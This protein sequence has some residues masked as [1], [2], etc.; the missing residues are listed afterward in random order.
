M[1]GPLLPPRFELIGELGTGAMGTVYAARDQ[2]LGRDVAVKVFHHHDRLAIDGLK[3][4]FRVAAGVRHRN[5]IRLGELFDHSAGWCFS[6][7]KIDGK[8]VVPWVARGRPGA[9]E[10]TRAVVAQVAAA[11]A[12][13]H[14]A[15]VIHLDVRPSNVLVEADGRVV[16][17][18]LG[19]A[20]ALS[21]ARP[22][23]LV[24]SVEYL[25]PEQSGADVTT[26]ATDVY[27]LGVLLYELLTGEPPFTGDPMQILAAKAAT[28]PPPPSQRVADVPDDLDRLCATLLAREPARRPTAAAVAAQLGEVN[29][30]AGDAER[31]RPALVGRDR[32]LTEL[33][34]AAAAAPAANRTTVVLL[35]GETGVGKTALLY[36]FA[37]AARAAGHL[38]CMGA[39]SPREHLRWNAWDGL[40]D[41]L[42]Q[43]LVELPLAERGALLPDDAGVLVHLFPAFGRVIAAAPTGSRS[44]GELIRR[45]TAALRELLRRVAATR[46]LVSIV[47]D[48][49]YTTDDSFALLLDVLAA[50]SAPMLMVIGSRRT[51]TVPAR[52]L[53]RAAALQALPIE[54]RVLDVG[55]LD[56]AASLALARRLTSDPARAAAVCAAAAG[57]P[58]FLEQLARAP[59]GLATDVGDLLR[60]RLTALTATERAILRVLTA[61]RGALRLDVIGG[62]VELEHEPLAHQLEALGDAGLV[63][64]SGLT[65]ADHA[66]V[67]H[68]SIGEAVDA[69]AGA[70][71]MAR[72]HAAL[73]VALEGMPYDVDLL[74]EHWVAAGDTGRAVAAVLAAAAAARDALAHGHVATLCDLVTTRTL[75]VT[76]HAAIAGAR[77][78]ALAG[79]GRIE[80]AALAYQDAATAT[81]G[82]AALDLRRTA[83]ELLLR[84]G[85]I[86]DGHAIAH[87]L[88]AQLGMAMDLPPRL[89]IG[90]I[91]LE[92]LRL[93]LRGRRLAAR[94]DERQR[95]AGATCTSLAIG[96]SM[97]DM[98]RA[99][100]F[101]SRAVRLSLDSGDPAAAALALAFDGA[102]VASRGRATAAHCAAIF[103]RADQLATSTTDATL[104]YVAACR[105]G[106]AYA[107]GDFAGAIEHCDRAR[108]IYDRAP[109]VE[110]GRCSAELIA[111]AACYWRGD[112]ATLARH[113]AELANAAE[114]TGDRYAELLAASGFAVLPDALR[115]D[116]AGARARLEQAAAHWP[117]DLAPTAQ[118]RILVG[119][120]VL[121]LYFGHVGAARFRIEAAW[122]E[123]VASKGLVIEHARATMLDLR[124]R[125]AVAGGDLDTAAA[126]ARELQRIAWATGPAHL[127]HAAVAMGRGRRGDAAAALDRAVAAAELHGLAAVAAAARFRRGELTAGSASDLDRRAAQAAAATLGLGDG[128]LP[129]TL[130]AP[131]PT[132]DG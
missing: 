22:A 111:L 12:A 16:L 58:L 29:V 17:L 36:D 102:L 94:R 18:D 46:R 28:D 20:S 86:A 80:A 115:G 60:D 42:S 72:A 35:R 126:A 53:A 41:F 118:F 49:R 30:G 33:L 8:D 85:R 37:A 104:G 131:W 3:Q 74:V 87:S 113:R 109:G 81:T 91:A 25:A 9:G 100:W 65:R 120:L 132:R 130:L 92:R 31:E 54:L 48:G 66:E 82:D 4:E 95:I 7:E 61:G 73:A 123:L 108:A 11:L 127:L 51:V 103:A 69:A 39:C 59:G 14:A 114:T 64:C 88:G 129:F 121:D 110:F 40:A 112:W 106:A 78:G 97:T 76:E 105:G 119:R 67:F 23:T 125:A 93:R 128:V 47:D 107:H 44:E 27:S 62:A 101:S 32:E 83:A 89:L 70:D 43:H 75:P 38:V 96:L 84:S 99:A 90:R 124:G 79:A 6:M 10:R 34:A 68:A 57:N 1:D 71:G 19:L 21:A 50:P 5:L 117:P 45:A 77:A 63:R 122:P 116:E 55:P 2:E 56:A 24:G 26:A 98:L 15:G 52:Q 13:L